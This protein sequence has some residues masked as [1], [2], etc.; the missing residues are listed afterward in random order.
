[1][2]KLNKLIDST[3]M[4]PITIKGHYVHVDFTKRF[5]ATLIDVLSIVPLFFILEFLHGSHLFVAILGVI[6]SHA[7]FVCYKVYFHY[8]YGATLGKMLMGIKVTKLDGT[9]ISFFQALSR[10]GIDIAFALLLIVANLSALS[11]IS[12]AEYANFTWSE[13]IYY[14]GQHLPEWE[15]LVFASGW[16]WFCSEILVLFLNK[17]KRTIRD[18][19]ANTVVI[20]ERFVNYSSLQSVI[21]IRTQQTSLS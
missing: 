7:A 11:T 4:L 13:S 16:V 5:V 10:S 6:A 20:H 18:Y 17:R 1:M 12:S 3:I 15:L 2:T 21:G 9:R 14:V 19:M 8:F